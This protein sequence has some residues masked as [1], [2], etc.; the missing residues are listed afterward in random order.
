MS[1]SL[2][3]GGLVFSGTLSPLATNLSSSSSSSV[4]PNMQKSGKDNG[5]K[6][7]LKNKVSTYVDRNIFGH[8]SPFSLFTSATTLKANSSRVRNALPSKFF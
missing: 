5:E 6:V 2:G 1:G 7:D 4:C 3:N 8:G